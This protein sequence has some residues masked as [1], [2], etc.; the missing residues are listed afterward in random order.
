M[1]TNFKTN[2]K[3]FESNIKREQDFSSEGKG[4]TIFKQINKKWT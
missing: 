2:I 3:G 4:R 1:S